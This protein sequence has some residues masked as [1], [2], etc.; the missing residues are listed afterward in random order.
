M[1]KQISTQSPTVAVYGATGHTGGYILGELRRRAFT[2]ILVGRNADRLRAAAEA[3]GLPDAEI[4]VADLNDHAALVAAFT[5]ADVVISGL[6]AFIDFGEAVL[7][8][9]IAAG[10][11]YTD[12][13]GEQ[14]FLRKVLNDYNTRAEAAG[15]TVV[16]GITD[17]NLSGDL[18]AYLTTRRVQGPA[19]LVISHLSLSGGH[20]SKGSA[21]TVLANLDSF[22]DGGFH[23][24]NGEF[25]TGPATR[26]TEMVFPGA[27]APTAVGKF[28]QSSVLTIPRHSDVSYVAGALDATILGHLS[29]FTAEAIEAMPDTPDSD[30]RYYLIVDTYGADGAVVRGLLSGVDSY[31]DSAIM[32]V[33]VAARL[34]TGV[35]KPGAL[36]PAEAFDPEDFLNALAPHGITFGIG[37]APARA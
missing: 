18:L 16:S 37:E 26:Y 1:T 22:R 4:R 21:K 23:Y 13:S 27:A 15:V 9:A 20:G 25:R 12:T 36:A 32:A 35:A 7:A 3:A 24:E 19:E 10:A 11:H 31:R 2:P 33:E 6:A 30:L 34:G 8:A 28:P 29:G 14:N 5:G 17:N